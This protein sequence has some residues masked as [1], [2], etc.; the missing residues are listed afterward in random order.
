MRSKPIILSIVLLFLFVQHSFSQGKSS[1]I[2]INIYGGYGFLNASGDYF[3]TTGDTHSGANNG[4]QS[5]STTAFTRTKKALGNGAHVGLGISYALNNFMSIGIDADYLTG[6]KNASQ[7]I[8]ADTLTGSFNSS[9]SVLSIIPNVS[10]KLLNKSKY[11]VYNTIGIITAVQTKFDYT[12]NGQQAANQVTDSY[13]Y[14]YG[15][16]TGFKDALGVQI[17]VARNIQ[18]FAELSGYFLS[19]KPTS[20]SAVL[21]QSLDG[22][23]AMQVVNLN[24]SYKNSGSFNYQQSTTDGHV[25]VTNASYNDQAPTHHFYSIGLNA[26]VR[27]NL[28]Y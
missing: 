27:I 16:N 13:K 21:N 9:H 28:P 18:V 15:S 5:N 3:T 19:A 2:S 10:F 17:D 8:P 11:H 1:K 14:H 24:V 4:N 6:K 12:Y 7:N 26:G 25:A 23:N 20:L 22:G